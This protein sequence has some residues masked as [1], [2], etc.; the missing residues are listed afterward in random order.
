M[1]S[2]WVLDAHGLMQFLERDS[3]FEKVKAIFEE[4]FKVEE[5]LLMSA[6]NFGEVNY[7]TL[8]ECGIEKAEKI[9]AVIQYLPID[10]VVVDV[11]LSKLAAEFK[12]VRRMSYADCFAA[13][14]A[15]SHNGTLITGDKEFAQVEDEIKVFWL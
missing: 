5:N 2:K 6:V 14:L 10:I 13:G 1:E 7:I 4:C 15:K 3:G 12:A 8:R 11:G 9:E